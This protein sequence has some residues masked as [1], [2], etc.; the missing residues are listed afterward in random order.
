MYNL[1]ATTNALHISATKQPLRHL[2]N[3][4]YIQPEISG[5]FI[6]EK[7]HTHRDITEKTLST[8]KNDWI[9]TTPKM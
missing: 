2:G 4:A 7:W 8:F 3:M 5:H 1:R 6:K 9:T